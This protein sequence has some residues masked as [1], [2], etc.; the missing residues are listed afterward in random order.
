MKVLGDHN[1]S[2]LIAIPTPNVPINEVANARLANTIQNSPTN[3]YLLREYET[4]MTAAKIIH[5]ANAATNH[6]ELIVK[7]G[8]KMYPRMVSCVA[9]RTAEMK[10]C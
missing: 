7:I 10:S 3:R 2:D 9:Q 8:V 6:G 4:S 5:V 1:G